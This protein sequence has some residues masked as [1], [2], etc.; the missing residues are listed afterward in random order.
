MKFAIIIEARKNST[1]LPN[2]I[3]FKIDK[4]SFLEFLVKR[5][6][7]TKLVKRI[8]IATTKKDN[9]D[10]VNIAK[11]NKVLWFCGSE[12]NV[13]KRVLDASKFFNVEYIVRIT[14]DCP[15]VDPQ[16]IDQAVDIYKKKK[17]DYV[18]NS[19]I[20]SFPDGMDVE[21]FSRKAL[22]KSY[23]FAKNAKF[24]EWTTWSI[25]KNPK[26]FKIFN[27][28]AQKKFYKPKIGLTLDYYDDYKLLKKIILYF[29]EKTN[30]TCLN[31]L[32][33]LK[34]KKNWININKN[35][36]RKVV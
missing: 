12:K 5:L 23:K 18:S 2:K 25:R 17:Y 4:L 27:I 35:V 1:R 28:I 13:I 3:L 32:N 6:K 21:V 11:K 14:S 7:R 19:Y 9:K 29:K 22:S 26:K 31:V 16:F 8:I 36:R 24:K 10:I 33:L 15:L 30:F 34:R 20:R